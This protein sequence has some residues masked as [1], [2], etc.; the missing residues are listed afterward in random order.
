MSSP[1]GDQGLTIELRPLSGPRI[2]TATAP[3]DTL[4]SVALSQLADDHAERPFRPPHRGK[5]G[6]NLGQNLD[7]DPINMPQHVDFHLPSRP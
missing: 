5:D 4:F 7:Q 1:L 2:G 6:I 3:R